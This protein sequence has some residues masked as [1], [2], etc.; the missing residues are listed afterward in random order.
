MSMQAQTPGTDDATDTV[1]FWFDPL[2]PW[3]WITSRWILEVT[4]VRD[5]EANFHVMSLAVLNAG[6]EL[7]EEYRERMAQAWGPV[8]VLMAA[9]QQRGDEILLPLYTAMGTRIHNGGDQDLTNVVVEAL[10]ELGL[11]AVLAAAPDT[12]ASATEI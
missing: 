10:A 5:I 9:A 7:P 8:R 6:R 12:G 2:C 3:C 4:R 1:D 11:P